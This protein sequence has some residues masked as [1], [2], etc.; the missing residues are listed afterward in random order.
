MTISELQAAGLGALL[1]PF[2]SATDDHQTRNAEALVSVGAGRVLQERDMSVDSL[3][4]CI[5]EL[6][7]D[8][9]RLLA[10]AEAARRSRV[11]DAAAQVADLCLAAGAPA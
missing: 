7:A 9:A 4:A 1:V 8:R 2:P 11:I 3:S 5:V 10:M 6:L